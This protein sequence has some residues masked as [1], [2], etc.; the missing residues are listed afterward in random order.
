[1]HLSIVV[2]D[3][4]AVYLISSYIKYIYLYLAQNKLPSSKAALRKIEALAEKYIL[5]DSLLFKITSTP[6]KEMAVLAILETCTDKIIALYQSN[7]FAGHQGMIKTYLTISDKSFIL[8]LIHY[9]RSYIKGCY[10]SQLKHSEKP[11]TRQLQTSINYRPLSRLSMILKV[12]QHSNKGHRFILCIIDEVT[13]YLVTATIYQFKAEE[14]GD[15]L[16]EHDVTKYCVP[17]F[18][19][20]DRG[21]AFM[22]SLM[23]Y[24]FFKV[25]INIKQSCLT[26]INH[27]KRSTKSNL[28]Q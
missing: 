15:V 22:S 14:I 24:L 26:I 13:N 3:I 20:M 4:Q 6:D 18:I 11:M 12:M 25:D 7:L 16:I 19:I 1:M 28:C 10:K 8:N 9:L 27:Y 23:N 17:D 5:L 2:K 21:S